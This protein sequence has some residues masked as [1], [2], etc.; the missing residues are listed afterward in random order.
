MT[1]V[2]SF[3]TFGVCISC[4]I[5][6]RGGSSVPGLMI[7][8]PRFRVSE[9]SPGFNRYCKLLKTGALHSMPKGAHTF[10]NDEFIKTETIASYTFYP[11]DDY[12][13]KFNTKTIQNTHVA[14][15]DNGQHGVG[16]FSD[17]PSSRHIKIG[18]C[19]VI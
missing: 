3:G 13:T 12:Y 5:I 14:M 8:S 1:P 11:L 4:H 9:R 19:L 17:V 15:E 6:G 7:I 10:M 2:R 18:T 16:V